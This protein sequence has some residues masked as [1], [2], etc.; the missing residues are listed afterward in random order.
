MRPG[1][2]VR[3]IGKGQHRKFAVRVKSEKSSGTPE[4]DRATEI[5][6]EPKIV[7]KI[8]KEAVTQ[9][10]SGKQT[11]TRSKKIELAVVPIEVPI[12]PVSVSEKAVKVE[13]IKTPETAKPQRLIELKGPN[14]AEIRLR[15]LERIT[16]NTLK[17]QM[18]L[19]K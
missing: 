19:M 9:A 18:I 4:E 3:V 12:A 1:G 8:K 10:N 5:E 14:A 13:K 7:V 6:L 16:Q 17:A 2:S 15:V 11:V